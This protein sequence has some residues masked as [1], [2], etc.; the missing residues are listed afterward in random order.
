MRRPVRPF[1]VEYKNARRRAPILPPIPETPVSDFEADQPPQT[2]DQP[3]PTRDIWANSNDAYEQALRAAEAVFGR[4]AEAPL[5]PP[6][7]AP[8]PDVPAAAFF[9]PVVDA[10]PASAP[11]SSSPP[12]TGRILEALDQPQPVIDEPPARQRGRPRLIRD[13]LPKPIR[14][15]RARAPEPIPAKPVIP[16]EAILPRATLRVAARVG[17]PTFDAGAGLREKWV[18]RQA[19]PPGQRWRRRLPREAWH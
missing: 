13:P 16:V 2:S 15:A 9:K 14:P 6:E 12:T 11:A 7:P 17:E 1:Q 19:L 3:A 4:R 5:A 18:T 8:Q 10:E